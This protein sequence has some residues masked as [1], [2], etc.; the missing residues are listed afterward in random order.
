M[1]A[2]SMGL[3]QW[4]REVCRE[5]KLSLRQAAVKTGLSHSTISEV[6]KTGVA[7]PE[8]IKKL[9]RAFSEDGSHH[10]L[11]LED[12]LLVL[13]GCRSRHSEDKISEPL[14]QLIDAVARFGEPQIKL[15]T[16]FAQYL[17]QMEEK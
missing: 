8:T 16:H 10:R 17:S 9:A 13:A 3:G 1:K 6:K 12:K 4:L 2:E 15:V 14:A 11:V 5:E 7:S